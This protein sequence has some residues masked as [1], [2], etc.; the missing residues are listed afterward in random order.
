M[1]KIPIVLSEI[2]LN[3]GY[4]Q[5]IHWYT[6]S[7]PHIAVSGVTGTGKTYCTKLILAKVAKHIPNSH[8]TVI[9]YK[10]DSDFSFLSGY[11]NFYRFDSALDGLNSFYARFKETQKSGVKSSFY[12][13]CFDE[14]A[15]FIN[16]LDKK[17]AEEA[18]K[19]LS[20]LLMLGRSFDFHLLLS[21]QKLSAE[22]FGKSRDQFSMILSLG[23]VSK[24][25]AGMLF[26]DY[27]E[28][29][30]NDR[31]RG[32]GYMLTN[33]TDF[34]PFVVPEIGS[35]EQVNRAIKHAVTR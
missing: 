18:K 30:K 4:R 19:K 29:L 16:S 34:Q 22:D 14:W 15:S 8:I 27:K 7:A 12:L 11:D 35:M 23:N 21:Q 24:E 6:D 10:G 9:D 3:A 1:P 17:E 33:G 28:H 20:N 31:K 25:V 2:M 5:Y 32:T 13:L 26:N